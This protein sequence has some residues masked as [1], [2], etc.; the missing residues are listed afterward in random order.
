MF[1]F[2]KD[3]ALSSLNESQREKTETD[4]QEGGREGERGERSTAFWDQTF[5]VYVG[6]NTSLLYFKKI[7]NNH[8]FYLN[9]IQKPPP[10]YATDIIKPT[11]PSRVL[12]VYNN[13]SRKW[14]HVHTWVSGLVYQDNG[15]VASMQEPFLPTGMLFGL[16]TSNLGYTF[17]HQ[18]S[19]YEHRT[20]TAK[21]IPM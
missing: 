7:C 17:Q 5:V 15:P 11:D 21:S 18:C 10:T 13:P 2:G 1:V 8:N 20:S 14:G 6:P 12:L 3:P 19:A 16:N 9:I 4:R